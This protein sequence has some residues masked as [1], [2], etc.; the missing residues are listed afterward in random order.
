M[1]A[2]YTALI[3]A[4]NNVTQPP[5]GVTGTALTGGMSTA[6]KL[7]A[8]NAWTVAAP[9]PANIPVSNI[10]GA[11]VPADF[12]ALTALQLQQLQFLLQSA[13]AVYAPPAGTIR[14]VFSTIFSGKATTLA[15]LSALVAPY[16][17]AIQSWCA[18]NRYPISGTS[19]NLNSSDAANAGLV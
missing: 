8:V 9:Q 7:A 4:W 16:D 10:I 17:N 12:M 19:G 6:Q 2:Y 14:S 18:A 13:Q 11:I 15:N 5:P 3:A 1:M